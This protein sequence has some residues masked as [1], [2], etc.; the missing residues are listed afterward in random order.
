MNTKFKIFKKVNPVKK[1][2]NYIGYLKKYKLHA[3]LSYKIKYNSKN[4]I[5]K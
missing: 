1:H 4:K 5:N 3:N 2:T